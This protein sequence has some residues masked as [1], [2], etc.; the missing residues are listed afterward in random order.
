M[1]GEPCNECTR[2][3][4]LRCLIEAEEHLPDGVSGFGDRDDYVMGVVDGAR[5]AIRGVRAEIEKLH[6]ELMKFGMGDGYGKKED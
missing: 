3:E 2:K 5:A 6:D 1:K 4:V